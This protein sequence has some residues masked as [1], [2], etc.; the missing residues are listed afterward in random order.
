MINL[1]TRYTTAVTAGDADYP[2]GSFKNDATAGDNSGTPFEAAWTNDIYGF[3]YALLAEDNV[4]PDNNVETAQA[5]Q[6]VEALRAMIRAE[7]IKLLDE[8]FT[9]G[10]TVGA[11]TLE[12]NTHSD[13]GAADGSGV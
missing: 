7:A 11:R 2:E 10:G 9:V 8:T 13:G 1:E 3:F 12:I 5:S 6:L 4:T